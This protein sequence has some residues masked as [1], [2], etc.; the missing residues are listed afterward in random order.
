MIVTDTLN[1]GWRSPTVIDGVTADVIASRTTPIELP[2]RLRIKAFHWRN[3]T[4][5]PPPAACDAIPGFGEDT[6]AR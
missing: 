1:K 6:P 4:G 3:P 5:G 2:D